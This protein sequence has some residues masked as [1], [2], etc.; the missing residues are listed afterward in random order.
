MER[1]DLMKKK[2][3]RVLSCLVIGGLLLASGSAVLAASDTETQSAAPAVRASGPRGAGMEDNLKEVLDSL[4][5]SSSITQE[6]ADQLLA[7]QAEK[8]A[9]MKSQWEEIKNLTPEERKSTNT[10]KPINRAG[11]S[12]DAVEQGIITEAEQETICNALA[13]NDTATQSAAS[14]VRAPGPRGAGMEDNLKEVL[15]SLVSSSS[16]TQEQA[17]QLLALQA[18][19]QAQMKSQWEKIKDL[20]PEERKSMNSEKPTNRSSI[21]SDAVEQGIITE[22]ERETICNALAEARQEQRQAE[23]QER[24]AELVSQGIISQ[25]QA[26]TIIVQIQKAAAVQQAELEKVKDMSAEE[27]QQYLQSKGE[28]ANLLDDLIADGTL[29]QAQADDV[30]KLMGGGFHKSP[31]SQRTE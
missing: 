11:I 26:D 17:D 15:A 30:A 14:A 1:R 2:L 24:F 31:P 8:Q 4:V 9:Q 13:A 27:R 12:S 28:K 20:T 10:E 29:T 16:I 6:Q 19:R 3:N 5:S 21:F 25:E 22:A 23:L 7:L 18:E